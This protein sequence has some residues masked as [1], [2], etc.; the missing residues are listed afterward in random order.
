MQFRNLFGRGRRRGGRREAAGGS[1]YIKKQQIEKSP[2]DSPLSAACRLLPAALQIS[3]A[4]DLSAQL[5]KNIIHRTYSFDLYNL[6]QL[7]VV[8]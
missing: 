4:I 6:F 8:N 7:A 2:L 1:I 5:V 3:P